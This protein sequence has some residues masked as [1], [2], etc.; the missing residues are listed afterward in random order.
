MT[1]STVEQPAPER[2]PDSDEAL[3]AQFIKDGDQTA[4]REL[5]ERH[6]ALVLSVC[7]RG[8]RSPADADDA[9]QAIANSLAGCPQV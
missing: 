8:S 2:E 4:F 7:R 9:F 1:V 3:L 6:A 5:V